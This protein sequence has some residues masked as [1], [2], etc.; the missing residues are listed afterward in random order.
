[1]KR[2]EDALAEA[3]SLALLA[4]ATRDFVHTKRLYV[5]EAAYLLIFS[6]WEAFLE[7]VMIRFIAGYGNKTG[8]MTLQPGRAFQ[9]N[10]SDAKAALY[11]SKSYLLWHS[12]D[13]PIKKSQTWFINA[14]PQTVISSAYSDI[15]NFAAIRHYVAHRSNDCQA[16][17]D[18]ATLALSGSVITGS[19][20]GRFLRKTTIDPVSGVTLQWIQRIGEDLRRYAKQIAD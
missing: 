5:F 15:A 1:M 19:R 11:G 4:E 10:L 2:F 13:Y 16:K 7:E 14:S 3:Q 20:A 18:N 12:P 6:A 17:F 9:P 8:K